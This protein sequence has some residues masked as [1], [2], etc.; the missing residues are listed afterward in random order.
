MRR[1]L[2]AVMSG[3]LAAFLLAG[4]LGLLFRLPLVEWPAGESP[5]LFI[6]HALLPIAAF[7]L[8]F[9]LA[10]IALSEARRVR[11]LSF[12]LFAGALIG[13]L[14][15]VA[16][17]GGPANISPAYQNMRTVFAFV[18]MGLAGGFVYWWIAGRHAGR[19]ATA[20]AI[21][22][23]G[24]GSEE[25]SQR[26][27]WHC[28]IGGICMALIPLA[29]FG[30]YAIYRPTP[31][32][33]DS[34]V[35][36]AETHA[37]KLLSQAGL[38]GLALNVRDHIGH[39]TGQA[40]TGGQRDKEFS[41]ATTVLAPLV[42]L[43]GVVAYL[44]NDIAVAA[45]A[46]PLE[47]ASRTVA[48]AEEAAK[49]MAEAEAAAKA[50]AQKIA[51]A[52]AAAKAAEA[53]SMAS[54][55]KR[56]AEAEE[57]AAKT[58][59]ARVARAKSEA[60]RLAA[61]LD[62]KRKAEEQLARV[63]ADRAS[64]ERAQE[65]ARRI[66][67]TDAER[68]AVNAA[69]A[70]EAAK[71]EA[72]KAQAAVAKAA[73]Q[74]QAA[75]KVAATE[76]VM[77][78][79]GGPAA[80]VDTQAA[81]TQEFSDLFR[82][83]TIRFGLR[84]TSVPDV[85]RDYLDK[86]ASQAKQCPGFSIAIGGHADRSGGGDI[87]GAVSQTRADAVRQFLI[88]RGVSADR[89]SATGYGAERPFAPENTRAAYALNRRVD[90]GAAPTII[91]RAATVPATPP[92]PAAAVE[93]KTATPPPTSPQPTISQPAAPEPVT[94]LPAI[95][96]AE[97]PGEF[98]RLFL[99]ETIH[100]KGNSARV[101]PAYADFLDRLAALLKACGSYK[102]DIGG[103]TDR[104]GSVAANQALSDARARRVAQALVARGVTASRLKSQGFAGER[105]FDP[106]NSREAFALNR[107]VGFGVSLSPP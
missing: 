3:L 34:I 86:I 6:A 12:W 16:L 32:L 54:E 43:P 95:A 10:A 66:A 8:P 11:G 89:V 87:N 28:A 1:S 17:S 70:E 80:S 25:Q 83:D 75:A 24:H 88:T 72:G 92:P 58:E 98:S 5:L 50:A 69:R 49:H 4:F 18:A 56:K 55:A 85:S 76:P 104:R 47:D 2:F 19:M 101:T 71:A 14:G 40:A 107:R 106:G 60:E 105:P 90:F 93:P 84:Q 77:E 46:E 62:A 96:A 35:A 29:L 79:A 91:K 36:R 59:A 13:V 15:F 30:W 31:I 65:E 100:F 39:I 20:L 41:I 99:S 57:A 97:C 63:A 45:D 82:S 67:E 44:Q 7:A 23:T 52:A 102:L 73:A 21:I 9:G 37:G 81:C 33:P 48:A 61:E 51:E 68:K 42:G 26:R 94:T 74:P 103:H 38:T 64:E 78:P 53:A 27:C 22:S